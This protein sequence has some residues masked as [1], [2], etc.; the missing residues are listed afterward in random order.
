MKT[1]K[2]L[3]ASFL[4]LALSTTVTAQEKT[5][6]IK[7]AGEC[8]MCKKTIESTAK[9]AG[10]SYAAWNADT[11]ELSVKFNS[12]ATDM[13]RI[14]KA[15][16]AE[17]YDTPAAKA[18]D[19]SYNKLEACCQYERAAKT[20]C[21]EA[22]ACTEKQCTKDGSCTKDTACCKESGCDKKACCKKA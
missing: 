3:I 16:A 7:V 22:P 8:G 19:E 18:S 12:N 10:A 21:C 6:K 5:E 9:K 15:I 17:G 20:S 13:A 2:I 14:Q 11:K 1:F 4:C